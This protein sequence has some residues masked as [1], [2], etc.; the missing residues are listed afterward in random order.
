MT[1][2][3]WRAEHKII[4]DGLR[5]AGWD[6][7]LIQK[8]LDYII[9]VQ[10]KNRLAKDGRSAWTDSQRSKVYKSEWAFQRSFNSEIK[11]FKTEA[12]AKKYANK[13]LKSATWKKVKSKRAKSNVQIAEK[14][15]RGNIAGQA[16]HNGSIFL[17][18]KTGMDEYT[19]IHELAH[20]AGYMHHDGS[21]VECLIKLV[22]RFMGTDKA[23]ALK[24]EFKKRKVKMSVKT[25][26]PKMPD[27]WLTMYER[28]KKARKMKG[29]V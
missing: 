7:D 5:D 13:I 19:L 27:A 28:T 11:M 29:K 3:G 15:F 17:D 8:Y 18:T 26:T 22:S 10:D 24:T 23:K 21:F 25:K 4:I 1:I 6:D 14:S 16:H 12:E 20:V 9:K 2:V